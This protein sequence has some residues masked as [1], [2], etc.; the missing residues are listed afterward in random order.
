MDDSAPSIID[1]H[2]TFEDFFAHGH[3]P[4]SRPIHE[5]E[6]YSHAVVVA[7]SRVVTCES[8]AET[9]KL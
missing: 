8:I 5:P 9:R 4:G 7:D 1:E 2:A 6:N 3:R